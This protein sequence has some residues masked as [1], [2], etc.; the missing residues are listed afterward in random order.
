[1]TAS[2]LLILAV[3]QT[4]DVSQHGAEQTDLA[5]TACMEI[6]HLARQFP[7]LT[8]TE[9]Q[10]TVHDSRDGSDHYGCRVV[11]ASAAVEY[12]DAEMPHDFLRM[13]LIS[14]GW[15]E[16]ISRAADG[17]GSTA[18]AVIRGAAVCLFS[19]AWNFGDPSE[20]GSVTNEYKYEAGCFEVTKPANKHMQPWIER[21]YAHSNARTTTPQGHP[22]QTT[23]VRN[24]ANRFSRVT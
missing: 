14:D 19:A 15:R 4:G 17:A 12:R 2:A 10:G 3:L 11:G 13:R 16:D 6:A 8:V 5:R 22:R 20:R 18:F 23:E 9:S 1:M 24:P 21:F 7:G